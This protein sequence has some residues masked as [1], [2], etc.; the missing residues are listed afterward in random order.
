M[1]HSCLAGQPG[2]EGKVFVPELMKV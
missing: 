2:D 1:R